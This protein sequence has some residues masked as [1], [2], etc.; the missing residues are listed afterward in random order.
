M[1]NNSIKTVDS[2]VIIIEAEGL[3]IFSD[4]KVLHIYI[5]KSGT[6]AKK[7]MLGI[8]VSIKIYKSIMFYQKPFN[9]LIYTL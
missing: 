7:V 3:L 6:V 1:L 9:N 5:K 2:K 8:K 4:A